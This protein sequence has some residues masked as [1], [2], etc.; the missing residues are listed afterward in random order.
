MSEEEFYSNIDKWI[1][2]DKS[3]WTHITLLAYFCKKYEE[4]NGV[5]FRLVRAKKGP[6]M[7]KEAADFAKLFRTLAPENYKSLPKD[8]KQE[9]RYAVNMK[10][11][12]FINW[13]F[14][15]KFRSGDK[16]VNGTKLFLVP[17]IINDFE[18]M[19]QRY[20]D[21]KTSASKINLLIDWCRKEASEIFEQHQLSRPDDV[22]LIKRYAD[23]Y[24]LDEHSIERKVLAKAKEV[25]L[26]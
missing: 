1:S 9:V 21:K 11:Y 8:K 3:K 19:Y 7:G 23:M 10:I 12:N 14:D 5:K 20:L 2:D 17:S 25:G 4:K 13:M 24:G 18:R 15:Y 6:T 26:I 16:S 22:G